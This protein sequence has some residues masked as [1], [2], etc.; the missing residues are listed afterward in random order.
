MYA[1]ISKLDPYHS[2]RVQAHWSAA[3]A[4]CGHA[5]VPLA[6]VPHFTWW[7]APD[8]QRSSLLATLAVLA[9]RLQPFPIST[10]GIGLFTQP[11]LVVY[12]PL[13]RNSRLL[14]LHETIWE[15]CRSSAP[16][17]SAHYAPDRWLP[18]VTL[19]QPVDLPSLNCLLPGLLA[20]AWQWD[21]SIDNLA[22]AYQPPAGPAEILADHQLGE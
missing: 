15:H 4:G 20:D 9:K 22:L 2:E 16:E 17:S 10:S 18:H 6:P 3:L 12:V 19:A 13:V 11:E 5:G 21:L 8:A 1:V 7:L 14:L